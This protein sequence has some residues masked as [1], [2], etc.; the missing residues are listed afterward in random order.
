MGSP[1]TIEDGTELDREAELF[2][3][4]AYRYRQYIKR[5]HSA[6]LGGVIWVRRGN[7]LIAYS[8]CQQYTEQIC[9]VTHSTAGD[10]LVFDEVSHP[11]P[12]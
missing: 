5:H 7:E 6:T 11:D 12:P 10:K 4:A 3:K 8:E 2:F 1:V 9:S